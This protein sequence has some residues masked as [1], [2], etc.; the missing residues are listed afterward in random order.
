MGGQLIGSARTKPYTYANH[1]VVLIDRGGQVRG[2]FVCEFQVFTSS[3]LCR[4][5]NTDS[6]P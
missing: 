4:D 3:L 5:L 6:W 2:D 1:F